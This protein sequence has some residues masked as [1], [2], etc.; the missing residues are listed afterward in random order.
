MFAYNHGQLD[1]YLQ[2]F[3]TEED[4]Q[5]HPGLILSNLRY[6]YNP[7]QIDKVQNEHL[8]ISRNFLRNNH[9]LYYYPS[10]R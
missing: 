6:V 9:I 5:K 10:I 1:K 4:A 2:A 8:I 7:D 3:V